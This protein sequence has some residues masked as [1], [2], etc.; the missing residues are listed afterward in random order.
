MKRNIGQ[1][2]GAAAHEEVKSDHLIADSSSG[3]ECQLASCGAAGHAPI[4]CFRRSP[5]GCRASPA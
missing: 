3:T 5:V 4:A 2:E 1:H